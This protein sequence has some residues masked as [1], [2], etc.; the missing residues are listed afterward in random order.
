MVKA[1]LYDAEGRD[2]EVVATAKVMREVGEQQLLWLDLRRDDTKG[3]VAAAKLLDLSAEA[4]MRLTALE[5]STALDNHPAHFQFSV[6]AP[7]R[8][9]A[10][11][12]CH[13]DFL[14]AEKW[15]LTVRDT[16]L[17]FLAA[18]RDQDRGESMKG[19]LSP[20]TVAASL[21]DWHLESYFD[22]ISEVEAALDALD[23]EVLASRADRAA[24]DRLAQMRRRVAALRG[25]IADQRAVFH[26]LVRPDF[27]PIADSD[28]AAHF[29]KLAT[30]FDRAVDSVER[31]RDVVVGS[32]D[33]FTSKTAQDTNELVKALTF[34][35]VVI[36]FTA[37]IAGLFGMNFDVPI[38]KTGAAGFYTV[39]GCLA[40]LFVASFVVA[41]W[42]KWI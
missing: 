17:E 10:K 14:V 22:S 9:G 5:R 12:S 24:L 23:G 35:T 21:L 6:P 27:T 30:R 31:A 19:A 29:A 3:L 37:A 11:S 26:G 42:R 32:F 34:F 2:R 33:L 39:L 38:F 1:T 13:L 36:G 18:F 7:P 8:D 28:A 40:A 41:R 15:L 16:D 20:A 25:S 4:Q